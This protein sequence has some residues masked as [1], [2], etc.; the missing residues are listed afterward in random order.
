MP[1]SSCSRTAS[2]L[3][4]SRWKSPL[5]KGVIPA[6]EVGLGKT[7]EAGLVMCQLWAEKKRH[8]LG[9]SLGGMLRASSV[10]GRIDG[11]VQPACAGH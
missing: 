9:D 6:D 10:G 4:Y 1:R 7:I 5:E 11:Q 2:T 8:I 3:Y